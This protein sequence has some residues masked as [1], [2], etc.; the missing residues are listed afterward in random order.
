[1]RVCE[2][3]SVYGRVCGSA[4][5]QYQYAWKYNALLHNQNQYQLFTLPHPLVNYLFCIVII[6]YPH[7]SVSHTRKSTYIDIAIA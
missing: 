4:V 6:L 3:M 5:N 2:R 7:A 1:M